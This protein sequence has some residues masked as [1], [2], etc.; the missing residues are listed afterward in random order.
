MNSKSTQKTKLLLKFSNRITKAFQSGALY[1]MSAIKRKSWLKTIKRLSRQL[2]IEIPNF[3][4]SSIAKVAVLALGLFAGANSLNAQSTFNA[5]QVNPFNISGG[6]SLAFPTVV[7]I[8]NDGDL[9]MF[10]GQNYTGGSYTSDLVFIENTGSAT[11]PNF[12]APINNAFNTG[13]GYYLGSPTFVD[14]DADGDFDLFVGEFYVDTVINPYYRAAVQFFENVGSANTPNFAAPVANPFGID[15]AEFLSN[16][17]FGDIDGDGDLDLLMGQSQSYV[18]LNTVVAFQENTGTASAPAF[19]PAQQDPF[20]LGSFDDVCIPNLVDLDGDGDLDLFVGQSEGSAGNGFGNMAFFEN[21]G[22]TTMANFGA[23]IDNPWGTNAGVEG[24][25]PAS[26]DI[27]NDGDFDLFVGG[28]PDTSSYSGRIAF[29]ENTGWINTPPTITSN[30]NE[31]MCINEGTKTINLAGIGDV[32]VMQTLSL[33]ATS[34]NTAV[35]ADPMVNFTSPGPTA[36]LDFNPT[37]VGM[38]PID[39]TVTDG[40]VWKNTAQFT[41]NVNAQV[42]TGFNDELNSQFKVYPNP[43]VAQVN[44]ELTEALAKEDVSFVITD[45]SGKSYLSDNA[46]GKMLI[47]ID[48]STLSSGIYFVKIQSADKAGHIK[49]LI[50]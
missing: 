25:Y 48:V 11:T 13:G 40:G 22:T 41:F 5:P 30:G 7:D 12:A 36:T 29:L 44:I 37:M 34:T 17:A 42:C 21:L 32:D 45:L 43:A 23:R 4:L 10:I 49:L 35:L 47:S 16:P 27:D 31:T 50:E 24:S 33:T 2:N 9:D 6:N 1:T 46:S 26:A 19:G 39:V 38:V 20:S 28:S 15:S 3:K 8:D 14:I 18:T